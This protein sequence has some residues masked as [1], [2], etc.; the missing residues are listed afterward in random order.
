MVTAKHRKIILD[1]LREIAATG[2]RNSAGKTSKRKAAAARR[3]G[4]LGG[5]PR[6][7]NTHG[8]NG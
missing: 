5:R 6:K 7:E 1:Y 3:N 4:K 2:G 8:N